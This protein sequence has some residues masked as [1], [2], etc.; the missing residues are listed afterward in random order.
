MK[1][2]LQASK[3]EQDLS[4]ALRH[5]SCTPQYQSVETILMAHNTLECQ[6]ASKASNSRPPSVW[7]TPDAKVWMYL[8]YLKYWTLNLM[9]MIVYPK[10]LHLNFSIKAPVWQ[11]P[12]ALT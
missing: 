4:E 11:T 6:S 7:Q 5:S 3:Y 2:P 12:A 9:P 8:V 10:V 1:H